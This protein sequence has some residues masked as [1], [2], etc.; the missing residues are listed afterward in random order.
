[1]T[2]LSKNFTASQY[3]NHQTYLNNTYDIIQRVPSN[4]VTYNLTTNQYLSQ[5]PD[6]MN[7]LMG[8]ES[9]ILL[10]NAGAGKT[11]AVSEAHNTSK[12]PF[13]FVV[14]TASLKQ[15]I[16]L[17][18]QKR[19]PK[20]MNKDTGW[21]YVVC[22]ES[23]DDGRKF[24]F[25]IIKQK[26]AYTNI[27][28]YFDEVHGLAGQS[29]RSYE[30]VV[31]DIFGTQCN[32]IIIRYIT[33]TPQ[34]LPQ[35][36]GMKTVFVKQPC[37]NQDVTTYYGTIDTEQDYEFGKDSI[38]DA[39]NWIASV[40]G[41]M[42]DYDVIW[43]LAPDNYGREEVMQ[44][45]D[46][47]EY[48]GLTSESRNNAIKSSL[49]KSKAGVFSEPLN[50]IETAVQGL[51]HGKVPARFV[52]THNLLSE[53]V[54]FTETINGESL[55]N[56]NVLILSV[57]KV[58]KMPSNLI[59]VPNRFRKGKV[60]CM[61]VGCTDGKETNLGLI[62]K[63]LSKLDSAIIGKALG[64]TDEI[65]TAK[66]MFTILSA[67]QQVSDNVSRLFHL[68]DSFCRQY[69]NTPCSHYK[70][71]P[72][73]LT[74]KTGVK[75]RV[76]IDTE[77]IKVEDL[78]TYWNNYCNS[79]TEK[80]ANAALKRFKRLFGKKRTEKMNEV[81]GDDNVIIPG[82]E[83]N[84]RKATI[85]KYLL[86]ETAQDLLTIDL[87]EHIISFGELE[88][89]GW[90]D[91]KTKT[92]CVEVPKID[93]GIHKVY[94][95]QKSKKHKE[96][97]AITMLVEKHPD[98]FNANMGLDVPR[99]KLIAFAEKLGAKPYTRDK[100]KYINLR[101]CICLNEE[102]NSQ[103]GKNKYFIP[104]LDSV[105]AAEIV[106]LQDEISRINPMFA[107]ERV[108]DKRYDEYRF[109][110]NFHKLM[111]M[112]TSDYVKI[113]KQDLYSGRF[114]TEV[115]S[116][117]SSSI[118]FFFRQVHNTPLHQFDLVSAHPSIL[119]GLLKSLEGVDC[120]DK[121]VKPK[122]KQQKVEGI[123]LLNSKEGYSE[124]ESLYEITGMEKEFSLLR[125]L[126]KG[127]K[128][129]GMYQTFHDFVRALLKRCKSDCYKK[130][131]ENILSRDLPLSL[132]KRPSQ[133]TVKVINGKHYA[134]INKY[135][136]IGCL[137]VN[138]ERYIMQNV[139][140]PEMGNAYATLKHDAVLLYEGKQF[141]TMDMF[142]GPGEDV[143][144]CA[145]TIV[146]ITDYLNH[147]I[148]GFGIRFAYEPIKRCTYFD[149]LS[150]DEIDL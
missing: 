126:L 7:E 131:L 44:L 15:E 51:K 104:Y 83:E 4:A 127:D 68:R 93:G 64:N 58:N 79:G 138:I 106:K 150:M 57:V 140:T 42:V 146:S 52:T 148:E 48:I 143:T 97:I 125:G 109:F 14:P 3:S 81:F 129:K 117:P 90:N 67:A 47:L 69:P 112:T 108:S 111:D 105:E 17:S 82:K 103:L 6:V 1:M 59:Q 35:I 23:L 77:D 136:Y 28:I 98:V 5:H 60:D 49:V 70:P 120:V 133:A 73:K 100:V 87:F 94:H 86:S 39:I 119:I 43:V 46:Q 123:K 88:Y 38:D 65:Y 92:I 27:A 19:F 124:L 89:S 40:K 11:Y 142:G 91:S 130:A 45:A 115:T 12:H 149:K 32:D 20:M 76:K 121:Y 2:N 74:K 63:Y 132:K 144:V 13:I 10:A 62:N 41:H 122:C 137:L 34:L 16:T 9:L 55:D 96:N 139:I 61:F 30:A 18:F 101:D 78:I 118:D 29:F 80:K 85:V 36:D 102:I 107:Q 26:H 37:L 95:Y 71:T 31:A 25:N 114:Y 147:L 22:P 116:M 56:K 66:G 99:K 135:S 141:Q 113:K 50:N 33:A 75:S 54:S 84:I 72:L 24:D 128:I 134:N 145:N 110:M 21:G 53:G 8:K